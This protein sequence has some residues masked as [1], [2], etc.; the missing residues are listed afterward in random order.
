MTSHPPET[1]VSAFLL[2]SLIVLMKYLSC[3]CIGI[4][5]EKEERMWLFEGAAE[6]DTFVLLG[7]AGN[8]DALVLA[9]LKVSRK[10]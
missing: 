5:N 2:L 9:F 6:L 3:R 8:R 4:K 7:K 1:Y 10:A